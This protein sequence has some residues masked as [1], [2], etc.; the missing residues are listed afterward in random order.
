MKL[1]TVK[2]LTFHGFKSKIYLTKLLT[3]PCQKEIN[4]VKVVVIWS[5]SQGCFNIPIKS[6]NKSIETTLSHLILYD[7]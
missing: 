7:W 6:D 2:V 3:G 4:L 5:N 1:T